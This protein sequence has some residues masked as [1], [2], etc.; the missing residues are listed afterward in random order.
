MHS[1]LDPRTSRAGVVGARRA[2]IPRPWLTEHHYQHP[3][4]GVY[5]IH[6]DYRY[7]A[8]PLGAPYGRHSLVTPDASMELLRKPEWKVSWNKLSCCFCNK[9]ERD[10]STN[11]NSQDVHRRRNHTDAPFPAFP[12]LRRNSSSSLMV[13]ENDIYAVSLISDVQEFP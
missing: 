10:A 6:H 8:P 5:P 13:N 12:I 3:P 4:P 11:K 7:A 9:V 2:P 1:G